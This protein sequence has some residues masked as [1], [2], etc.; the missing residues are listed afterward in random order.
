MESNSQEHTLEEDNSPTNYSCIEEY[1]LDAVRHSDQDEVE[2]C[3]SQP[4][5]LMAVDD[6]GSTAIRKHMITLPRS[7]SS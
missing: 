4:L 6:N 2:Y 7:S 1:F 5:N 3:L